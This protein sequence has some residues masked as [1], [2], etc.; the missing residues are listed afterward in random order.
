MLKTSIK[1]E[2]EDKIKDLLS[3]M[4]ETAYDQLIDDPMLLCLDCS[5]VDIYIAISS[6]EEL[7]DSL[8]DSFELDEFG[9]VKDEK[10]YDQ[11]LD[12]LQNY[13]VQLHVESGRFDYFPAGLYVVN[14]NER[15]SSTEMLG[16]KGVFFA[17]FEDARK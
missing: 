14:G 7:E 13:F 10:S 11:L 1:L 5:D 2:N 6:H 8:K 16:P 17:P 15:T 3:E 4:V 12:E 9:D